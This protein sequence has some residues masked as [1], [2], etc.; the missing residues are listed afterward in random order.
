MHWVANSFAHLQSFRIATVPCS[1][2]SQTVSN[3]G[4]RQYDWQTNENQNEF[5][6]YYHCYEKV[7]RKE[8]RKPTSVLLQVLVQYNVCDV[9]VHS[10]QWNVP[11]TV[12]TAAD[13]DWDAILPSAYINIGQ[14]CKYETTIRAL[15]YNVYNS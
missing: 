2:C 4:N 8:L 6:A 1:K 9:Y 3:K 7:Y 14:S 5:H 10:Y 13:S 12:A 11:I 15:S